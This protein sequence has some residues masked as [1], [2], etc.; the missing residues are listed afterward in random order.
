[1]VHYLMSLRLIISFIIRRVSLSSELV[2][3][4]A[5][6]L[7]RRS[8]RRQSDVRLS[9]S[10][11][12]TTGSAQLG[13][14]LLGTVGK[15]Q[16]SES[17]LEHGKR[18]LG[19][20]EGH[21]VACLVN[22]EEADCEIVSICAAIVVDHRKESL[23]VTVL[24]DLTVLGAINHERLVSSSREL[25]GMG[26]VD[27]KGDGL[28]TEPIADVIR[29]TVEERNAKS[30]VEQVLE[31]LTEVGEDEVAGVLELPVVTCVNGCSFPP[32]AIQSS[33]Q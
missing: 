4:R 19:L 6:A 30:L 15:V 29:V 17:A 32:F 33:Y 18:C 11:V 1:M 12:G 21:F 25:F 23:T 3:D 9:V 20:V 16:R 7:G 8:G 27:L 22:A 2:S 24:P 28:A 10:C 26:V 14:D 13:C 31:I 5:R